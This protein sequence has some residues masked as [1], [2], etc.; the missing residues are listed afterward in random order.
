M[1]CKLCQREL[2]DYHEGRLPDDRRLKVEDHLGSCKK[3]ASA[4]QIIRLTDRIIADEKGI[5]SNPFLSTRVMAAIE[6]LEAPARVPVPVFSRVLK[7]AL[8]TVSLAAA[9]F[10]GV[11]MGNFTSPV[12]DSLPIEMAMMN[13]IEIESVSMLSVD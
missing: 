5:Q 12:S 8:V 2:N 13:D 11:V 3:C 4:Y 6:N 10:F 1:N 9:I 7:P